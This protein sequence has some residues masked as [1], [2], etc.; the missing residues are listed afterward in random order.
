[1]ERIRLIALV[2]FS[3]FIVSKTDAQQ[4]RIDFIKSTDTIQNPNKGLGLLDSLSKIKA[5]DPRTRIELNQKRIVRNMQLSRFEKV[6]KISIESIGFAKKNKL[7]SLTP[8]FYMMIGGSQYSRK[9][10][11]EAI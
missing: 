7:D 2:L 4:S 5:L 10:F 9:N 11:N 8:Y 1:M 3:W 6:S